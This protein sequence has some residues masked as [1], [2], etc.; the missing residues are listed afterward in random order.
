MGVA[1]LNGRR[2]C[3]HGEQSDLAMGKM[4]EGACIHLASSEDFVASADS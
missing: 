4:P 2:R 3:A 1:L